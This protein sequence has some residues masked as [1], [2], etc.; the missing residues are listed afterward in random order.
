MD[1]I[2]C[3]TLSLTW[4]F[5]HRSL[6][7]CPRHTLEIRIE[8]FNQVSHEESIPTRKLRERWRKPKARSSDPPYQI[9]KSEYPS[10]ADPSLFLLLAKTI[11]PASYAVHYLPPPPFLPTPT[12]CS[13]PPFPPTTPPLL[14]NLFLFKYS[15]TTPSTLPLSC[16]FF[17]K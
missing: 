10:F 8:R 4:T 7:T 5:T 17:L 11:K 15:S 16:A 14:T 1:C 13:L 3:C 9:L 2:I 12:C 6:P